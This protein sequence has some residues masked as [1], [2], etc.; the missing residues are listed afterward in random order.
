M[1]IGLTGS[2]AGGPRPREDLLADPVELADMPEGKRA[3]EGPQRGGRHHPVTQHPP[4]DATAQQPRR[5]DRVLVIEG[6]LDLV[7]HHVRG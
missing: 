2:G 6:D 3:Q 5:G 4:G 7:Q 1:V